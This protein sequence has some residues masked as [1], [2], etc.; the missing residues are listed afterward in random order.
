MKRIVLIVMTAS[1]LLSMGA[2]N[3][4]GNPGDG[5]GR[6]VIKVTDAPFDISAI[7]SATVTITR[8]EIKK[9]GDGISDGN[10][11]VTLSDDTVTID[12]I[13]LRNGI[14]ETL[15][16]MDIP[17]GE[18]DMIRLYVDEAGLKLRDY[19]DPYRVKVPS[20][21]QTGIK[22]KIYP[23]LEV[24]EG[25]TSE[26]L[27]DVDLSRSFVLRGNMHNN[28]G[29]IFKPVIRAANLTTAGRIEGMVTDTA[30]VKIKEA[31]LWLEQ[32]TVMATAFADTLGFYAII[33]IP[34]GT[35]SISATKEGY[36]TVRF[37]GVKIVAGNKTVRNFELTKK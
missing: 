2:C 37:D 15:L 8:V 16:E 4:T 7:E 21:S 9:V 3:E 26:L 22:I 27:L 29:F 31:T 1:F 36:D 30:D 24:A 23:Y 11:F 34:A 25:L 33:G 14:T 18:Y 6:V 12:L 20:G 35:Y 13:D 17:A 5:N 28:N 32:D 19:D 10:P